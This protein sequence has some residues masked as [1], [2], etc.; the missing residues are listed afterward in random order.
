MKIW[1]SSNQVSTEYMLQVLSI[2]PK[3]N[4][5]I[6]CF[7]IAECRSSTGVI[8]RLNSSYVFKPGM[9]HRRAKSFP[10]KPAAIVSSTFAEVLFLDCDSYATRDP[11]ELFL[12]DP[13]Y[14]KFGALFF[15][16]GYQSRQ[17]PFVWNVFNTSFIPDEYELDSAAILVDK[18]RVWD[19]LYMTKLINDHYKLFYSK[20]NHSFFF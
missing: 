1:Y 8:Q 12:T 9:T 18:R 14:L 6:C 10:Y 7:L 15:P 11:E 19:G 5:T 17:H 20:V 4:V 2:A 16:D 13:M 3:L